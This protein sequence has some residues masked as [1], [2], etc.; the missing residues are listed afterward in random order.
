MADSTT[1]F[2]CGATDRAILDVRSWL[3]LAITLML[4]LCVPWGVSS[5]LAIE[6]T[7]GD[8]TAEKS[9][10]PA[11]TG[12]PIDRL[13]DALENHSFDQVLAVAHTTESLPASSGNALFRRIVETSHRF[14]NTQVR[15]LVKLV[16][17]KGSS[18]NSL[19]AS[20]R[21]PL[22]YAASTGDWGLVSAL[23]E[24]GADP[25]RTGKYP[26][27]ATASTAIG[28]FIPNVSLMMWCGAQCTGQQ[29][30][31]VLRA[32]GDP[33]ARNPNGENTFDF[34]LRGNNAP[35]LKALLVDDSSVEKFLREHP[36]YTAQAVVHAQVELV[37]LL[38]DA[39]GNPNQPTDGGSTLLTAVLHQ[40]EL[41][42]A[43]SEP[44]LRVVDLLL[45]QGADP[46]LNDSEGNA[47]LIV[48]IRSGDARFVER[49]LKAS[50]NAK[51]TQTF[52]PLLLATWHK[53][54][55]EQDS[56]KIVTALID[57]G[58]NVHETGVYGQNLLSV[59][60]A[61][62][63]FLVPL[64]LEHKLD[65]NQRSRNGYTPL[66]YAADS[67]PSAFEALKLLVEYGADPNA[68]ANDSWTALMSAARAGDYR[69][70]DFLMAHGADPRQRSSTGDTAMQIAE[71]AMLRYQDR[72]RTTD[73]LRH[74]MSR[75]GE[76]PN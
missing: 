28:G 17:A 25:N 75:L 36:H 65:V 24:A 70:V 3:A 44:L 46:N 37:K 38:L 73:L 60:A 4:S 8:P 43:L 23:L 72:K 18:L 53:A 12:D 16:S 22:S 47:P 5:S 19:D 48:A 57:A 2:S 69:T 55:H 39:G 30:S 59:A 31:E 64:F 34:V 54:R 41:T 76:L 21:L 67:G 33:T 45:N 63:P 29:I 27:S 7:G 15:Q 66:M 62:N 11:P 51:H 56:R 6:K 9:D 14:T 68:V 26:L 20:H 74:A 32:G 13:S 35:A 42:P 58:A 40:A 71:K 10:Q 52:K 50:A 61:Y 1:E 49:L